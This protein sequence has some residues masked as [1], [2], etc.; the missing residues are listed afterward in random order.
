MS[1]LSSVVGYRR[2]AR[3]RTEKMPA[4]RDFYLYWV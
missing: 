3:C 4:S 2:A 1:Y